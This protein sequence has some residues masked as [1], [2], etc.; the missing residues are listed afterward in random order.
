M[1]NGK[2]KTSARISLKRLK[3]KRNSHSR[4]DIGFLRI[5]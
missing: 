1:L 2:T 4:L 3:G 5:N